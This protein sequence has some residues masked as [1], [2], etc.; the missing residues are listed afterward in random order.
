ME[1]GGHGGGG[2]QQ[3]GGGGDP[4]EVARDPRL[5]GGVRG[6]LPRQVRQDQGD[7]GDLG[8]GGHHQQPAEGGGRGDLRQLP[9]PGGRVRPADGAG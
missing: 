6:L 8:R 4:E 5:H 9:G 7:A 2:A 3:A 1:R